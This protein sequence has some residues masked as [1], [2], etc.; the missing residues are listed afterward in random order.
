MNYY[1]FLSLAV[2]YLN[3]LVFYRLYPRRKEHPAI[4]TFMIGVLCVML[5]GLVDFLVWLPIHPEWTS[6]LVRLAPYG[7][8]G[9]GYFALRFM[10][11]Y[12]G[13]TPG[14]FYKTL[15]GL[16]VLVYLS[17]S[18]LVWFPLAPSLQ[19]PYNEYGYYGR[20]VDIFS[21][22]AFTLPAV[23]TVGLLLRAW[24]SEQFITRRRT[25]IYFFWGGMLS[26]IVKLVIYPISA[27]FGIPTPPLNLFLTLISTLI[28]MSVIQRYDFLGFNVSVVAREMFDEM[29]D[30]ILLLNKD[31]YVTNMN[32]AA[33][34]VLGINKDRLPVMLT[35]ILPE[36]DQVPLSGHLTFLRGDTPRYLR[37][38][39]TPLHDSWSGS[40]RLLMLHDLTAVRQAEQRAMEM[41]LKQKVDSA[42]D[43]ERQRVAR[44]L[45][46]GISQTL[47]SIKLIAEILPM[48]LKK[49]PDS[50][51]RRMGE[52]HA[53]AQNASVEM[54]S[55]LLEL[56]PERVIQTPLPVLLNLLSRV[57]A[58][59]QN[60]KIM[61]DVDDG[62]QFLPPQAHLTF[63]RI[64]QE[65]INNAIRHARMSKIHVAF[66]QSEGRVLLQ[67][68]DDGC[69]F[70]PEDI[71][72]NHFGLYNM[73]E[74][75][76]EI[77]AFLEILSSPGGGTTVKLVWDLHRDKGEND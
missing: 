68:R 25:F 35:E 38:S 7:S 74:R 21:F 57:D 49:N 26:L 43:V 42:M 6:F 33:E 71:Q 11:A 58:I 53:L 34:S 56:R 44:D 65:S 30:G 9:I 41:E 52:L 5:W 73:R 45:H 50:A 24:Q 69:G 3:S 13:I 23:F 63:Y 22:F 19:I 12:L 18:Y 76:E 46:D 48:L 20:W 31:N 1:A 39:L 17:Y 77:N 60:Q 61:I 28:I 75:A 27:R 37:Y 29:L 2:F 15:A 59:D 62:I 66:G 4:K 64:A 16:I 40:V 51:Q 47:Y 10:Y 54:R 14:R 36:L 67:V 55:L 8:F 32:P 70:V 72:G